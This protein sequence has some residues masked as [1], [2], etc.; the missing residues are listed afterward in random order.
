[1]FKDLDLAADAAKQAKQPV[2]LGAVA[3]QLYQTLSAQGS[4]AKIS[5]R[6]SIC[7]RKPINT[8]NKVSI[9]DCQFEGCVATSV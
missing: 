7:S 9:G 6:S 2:V 4:G 8:L 5:Q 1:M 3:Q